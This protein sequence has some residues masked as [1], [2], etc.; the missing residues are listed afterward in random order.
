MI[1]KKINDHH[2]SLNLRTL[3]QSIIWSIQ[4]KELSIYLE[5]AM[6]NQPLEEILNQSITY[7]ILGEN[8]TA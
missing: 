5:T 6:I 2:F 7:L 8:R 4:V 1:I 3:I